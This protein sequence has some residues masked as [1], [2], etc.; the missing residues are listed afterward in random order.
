M[1]AGGGEIKGNTK[2]RIGA[3]AILIVLLLL[4]GACSE[5]S[6][7]TLL[8]NEQ[9]GDFAMSQD[10]VNV[11]YG[12][13]YYVKAQGG[14]LPYEFD[15]QAENGDDID[16]QTGYYTAP[17]IGSDLLDVGIIASDRF[18]SSDTMKI[19]LY[20][21]LE[22]SPSS[23][24]IR[25]GETQE[26]TVSGG[27]TDAIGYTVAADYG[28]ITGVSS[29]FTYT[30]PISTGMDYIEITDEI[31][32]SI[33]ISVQVLSAGE[34]GITPTYAVIT[35]DAPG[36]TQLFTISGGTP[37]YTG[38]LSES[39]GTIP[40]NPLTSPFT[41]TAPGTEGAVI[42]SVTDDAG[43]TVTADIYVTGETPVTLTLSPSYVEASPGAILEFIAVGGVPP[44]T[45][46]ILS[47]AGYLEKISPTTMRIETSSP[48]PLA[49]I[50]V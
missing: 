14:F 27:Y 10:I 25:M 37:D 20:T 24:T 12:E 38:T 39:F 2:N 45:F 19:R 17:Q 41:Y 40:A 3:A 21:H 35:P 15:L 22:A 32:N 9:E 23:F 47:G 18:A 46:S 42:L 5:I 30:P 6:L 48:P 26:F 49:K 4:T 31:N 7:L 8:V 34:L 13:T 44:Y 43:T 11:S 28:T 1:Y 50:R 29:P 33:S 16:P 36:N